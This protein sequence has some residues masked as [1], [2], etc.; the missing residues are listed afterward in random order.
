M[1]GGVVHRRGRL[2]GQKASRQESPGK[3]K[4]CKYLE[5]NSSQFWIV[6]SSH[7]HPGD[8]PAGDRL[9]LTHHDQGKAIPRPPSRSL[10]GNPGWE[11]KNPS[12]KSGP[13]RF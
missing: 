11:L 10:K 5:L 4:L 3:C 8:L 1:C 12:L 7:K 13:G 9:V 2:R 6:C